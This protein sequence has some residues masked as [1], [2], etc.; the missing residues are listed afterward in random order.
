[1][2]RNLGELLWQDET[3]EVQDE[4]EDATVQEFINDLS[5][6]VW[7]YPEQDT[8]AASN[9]SD[10]V[11]ISSQDYIPEVGEPINTRIVTIE[12]SDEAFRHCSCY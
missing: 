1:M 9:A 6:L 10:A 3:Q 12:G 2:V 7:D 8:D 5:N 4:T 11:E